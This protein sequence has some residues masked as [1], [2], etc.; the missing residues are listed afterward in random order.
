M[1]KLC[2]LAVSLALAAP[3]VAL[4]Q[5]APAP[6]EA[7]PPVQ[8]MSAPTDPMSAP[9]ATTAGMNTSTG[10]VPADQLPPAQAGAL[11]GGDNHMVTNGPVPDTPANRAKFG[12]PKSHAGRHT[13]PVGN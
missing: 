1:K 9:A 10:P 8:N 13:K 3:A 12:G 6:P 4:A 7:A 11:A 2:V 5:T